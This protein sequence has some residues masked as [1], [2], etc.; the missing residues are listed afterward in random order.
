MSMPLNGCGG[1]LEPGQLLDLR[2]ARQ[3]RGLELVDPLVDRRVRGVGPDDAGHRE[4]RRP[5]PRSTSGTGGARNAIW[6]RLCAPCH[7]SPSSRC[8]RVGGIA[9]RRRSRACRLSRTASPRE[10]RSRRRSSRPTS[11]CSVPISQPRWIQAAPSR[12]MNS[13]SPRV[14]AIGRK[15]RR[16]VVGCGELPD[17][18]DQQHDERWPRRTSPWARS[19]PSTRPACRSG[20]RSCRPP[21]PRPHTRPRA[22]PLAM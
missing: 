18:H 13:R 15:P 21:W 19:R 1:R 2:V 10:T 11:A 7:A 22:K 14:V 5:P 6:S 16:S 17:R 3:G 20:R 9:S 4:A 12:P 8:R